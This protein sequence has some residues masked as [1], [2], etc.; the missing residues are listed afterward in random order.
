MSVDTKKLLEDCLETMSVDILRLRTKS[1]DQPLDLREGQLLNDYIKTLSTLHK[2]GQNQ[3]T[4]SI[5]ELT[6]KEIEEKAAEILKK[7]EK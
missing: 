6:L 3:E 2:L 1:E 5:A 4:D 7:R